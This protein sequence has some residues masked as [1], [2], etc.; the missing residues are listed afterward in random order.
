MIFFK[1]WWQHC[2]LNIHLS[3][4]DTVV[5]LIR[6]KDHSLQSMHLMYIPVKNVFYDS[7]KVFFLWFSFL[8]I[9]IRLLAAFV[10]CFY[11]NCIR[12]APRLC[13]YSFFKKIGNNGRRNLLGWMCWIVAFCK[14][15]RDLW[16]LDSLLLGH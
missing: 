4:Y 15:Q 14:K 6:I 13:Y 3:F 7:T 8:I 12:D 10:I 16:L 1:I 2:A 11:V 9:L 5:L